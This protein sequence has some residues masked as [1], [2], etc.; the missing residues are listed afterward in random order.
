M[1][2]WTPQELKRF[3]KLTRATVSRDQMERIEGR[4]ALT[5]FVRRKGRAKCD[6]M[7]AV[8]KKRDNLQDAKP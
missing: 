6:A 1:K 3:D 2:Q 4:L 8:I 7:W 5:A